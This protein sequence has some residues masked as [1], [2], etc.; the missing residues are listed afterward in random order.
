MQIV[1]TILVD[2]TF[3]TKSEINT[4]VLTVGKKRKNKSVEIINVFLGEEA[5]DIYKK[6]VGDKKGLDD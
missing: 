6:L 5:I 2:I 1:D 4:A 3:D